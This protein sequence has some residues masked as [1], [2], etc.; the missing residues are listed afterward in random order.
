MTDDS[1]SFR[2]CAADTDRL[3]PDLVGLGVRELERDWH[4]VDP[5][6]AA[7]LLAMRVSLLVP[8]VLE[9]PASAR[10]CSLL[11]VDFRISVRVEPVESCR[12]RA[13]C[14]LNIRGPAGVAL[15]LCPRAS[16]GA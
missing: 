8:A 7:S 5:S 15:G 4:K 3:G 14:G 10:V 2:W 16:S 12:V 11:S 6:V 9:T 13:F 1:E